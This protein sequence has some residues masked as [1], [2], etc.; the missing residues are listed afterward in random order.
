TSPTCSLFYPCDS[1]DPWFVFWK[2]ESR[3]TGEIML[4]HFSYSWIVIIT[5]AFAHAGDHW[6]GWRGPT[7]DGQ[8][9]EKNLPLTWGGKKEEN[10]LWKTPLLPPGKV[11]PDQNQSSPIVWGQRV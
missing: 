8:S 1:C 6:P 3:L 9:D 10:V 7:G 2:L 5:T 11:R 4:R